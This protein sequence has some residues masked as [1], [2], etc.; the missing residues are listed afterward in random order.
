MPWYEIRFM[1]EAESES[2][3]MAA[4]DEAKIATA[5]PGNTAYLAYFEE[6]K[7][8]TDAMKAGWRRLRQR[9]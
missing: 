4:F 9:P 8:I 2:D 6:R 1:V 5:L 7:G 3:F